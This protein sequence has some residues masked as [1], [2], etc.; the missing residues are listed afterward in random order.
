MRKC[1]NFQVRF[2]FKVYAQPFIQCLDQS[3]LRNIYFWHILHS[4][5]P[6][7]TMTSCRHFF[8]GA[9]VC[10]FMFPGCHLWF[11]DRGRLERVQIILSLGVGVR[12][13]EGDEEGDSSLPTPPPFP[14][15]TSTSPLFCIFN[16]A[17]LTRWFWEQNNSCPNE[18]ASNA[19]LNNDK[20]VL[21]K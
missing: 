18:K 17:L 19:G 6:G 14:W 8:G 2:N 12:V 3:T 9:K 4:H 13:K 7:E 1:K 11:Y 21:F 16:V 15:L 5:T 20:K 10:L